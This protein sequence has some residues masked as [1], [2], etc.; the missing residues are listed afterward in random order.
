MNPSELIKE[1]REDQINHPWMDDRLITLHF[2]EFIQYLKKSKKAPGYMTNIM[3]TVKAFYR[4]HEID[5]PNNIQ[6]TFTDPKTKI[7]TDKDILTRKDIE[8]ALTYA[9]KKYQAIILL[10]SSS[11]MGSAELRSLTV[12]NYLE[13]LNITIDSFDI[14]NV[15]NI[16]ESN[17]EV[18]TWNIIRIKTGKPYITFSSPESCK[19]INEYLKERSKIKYKNHTIKPD[20]PLFPNGSEFMK[21]SG[22]PRYFRK[23][24]NRCGFGYVDEHERTVF[25]HCHGLRKFFISKLSNNENFDYL[26]A[27]WLTGHSVE[28]ITDTY[29]KMNVDKIK[30]KYVDVLPEIVVRDMQNYEIKALK[31]KI[32]ETEDASIKIKQLEDQNKHLQELMTDQQKQFIALNNRLNAIERINA[33]I[34]DL[35]LEISDA[36]LN[37]DKDRRREL[38]ERKKELNEEKL[39]LM[40]ENNPELIEKTKKRRINTCLNRL[41]EYRNDLKKYPNNERYANKVKEYENKLN[42]LK[43]K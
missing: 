14:N 28:S 34:E 7:I 23:L 2:V 1:A 20:S 11:G 33:E 29:V 16:L 26:M 19:A 15:L 22:I 9:N 4:S 21:D 10:A 24:N 43:N 17:N 8:K 38:I 39:Y 42:E 30:V 27:L 12:G 25:F 3:K 13:S 40:A 31:D 6:T 35:N 41:K 32:L 5:I 37:K 36:R 18:P